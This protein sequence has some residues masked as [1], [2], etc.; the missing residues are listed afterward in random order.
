MIS[1][2]E[3]G[4]SFCVYHKG[5]PVV[6]LWGGYAD[7]GALRYRQSDSIGLFYSSTKA[8]TAITLALLADR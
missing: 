1:R 4:S 6:D 8:V 3:E 2:E 7:P 5:V